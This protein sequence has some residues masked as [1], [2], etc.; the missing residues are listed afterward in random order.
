MNLCFWFHRKRPQ[1]VMKISQWREQLPASTGVQKNSAIQLAERVQKANSREQCRCTRWNWL[2]CRRRRRLS[3]VRRSLLIKL[4]GVFLLLRMAGARVPE[5]RIPGVFRWSRRACDFQISEFGTSAGNYANGRTF[6]R[7]RDK[8][9][10][11]ECPKK[12]VNFFVVIFFVP[13]G[14]CAVAVCGICLVL[15]KRSIRWW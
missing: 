15:S 8:F 2:V 12:T 9:V 11:F 1:P 7:I 3:G 13:R 5:I 6:E 4:I 14:N 10:L